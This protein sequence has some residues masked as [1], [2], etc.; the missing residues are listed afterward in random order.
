MSKEITIPVPECPWEDIEARI[1][2]LRGFEAGKTGDCI[3]RSASIYWQSGWKS[4][5]QYALAL[6][7]FCDQEAL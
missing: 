2:W 1:S 6:E 4:G 3:N 7:E 5:K